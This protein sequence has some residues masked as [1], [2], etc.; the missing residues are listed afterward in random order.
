MKTQPEVSGEDYKGNKEKDEKDSL[1]GC[2]NERM[3]IIITDI[4]NDFDWDPLLDYNRKDVKDMIK[5]A[6]G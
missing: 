3:E 5:K 6:L 4:C 1:Q 2:V